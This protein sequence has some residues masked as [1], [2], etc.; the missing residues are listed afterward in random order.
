MAGSPEAWFALLTLTASNRNWHRQCHFH[1]GDRVT[2]PRGSRQSV[3]A[4]SGCC[5]RCVPHH[6]SQ[7]LGV[8][9]RLHRT[10]LCGAPG[11]EL[12][13][14]DII[15]IA[16]G[17][18]LIERPRMKFMPKSRRAMASPI[19]SIESQR[20]LLGDP[21]DIVIDIVFSLDSIITAIGMAQDI[22]IMVAAVVIACVILMYVHRDRW[23]SSWPMIRPPKCWRG[24]LGAD[25][26]G[27]GG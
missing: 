5:W 6:P 2:Y 21:A 18:F 11:T 4:R 7:P 1:F 16:G 19:P 26:G 9:D 20:V 24:V 17:A 10:G 25:R 15:L 12:S 8:A 13:W 27:A 22:E 23:R 14:R 3:R